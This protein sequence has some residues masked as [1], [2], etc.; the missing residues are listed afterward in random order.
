MQRNRSDAYGG[1]KI[2][3]IITKA[4]FIPSYITPINM[5]INNST[6][7]MDT[8]TD[9]LLVQKILTISPSK[10]LWH[11]FRCR[12]FRV[13]KLSRMDPIGKFCVDKLSRMDPTRK[14]RV[15]KLSRMK[16]S[17]LLFTTYILYKV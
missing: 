14:F 5:D 6:C 12:N 9:I 8:V 16:K 1:I 13:E 15:D 4:Y 3:Y 17:Q 2:C 11:Y 10:L 7:D